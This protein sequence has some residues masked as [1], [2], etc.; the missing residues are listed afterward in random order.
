M[1]RCSNKK[2]VRTDT[3]TKKKIIPLMP[4][5][6]KQRMRNK[7]SLMDLDCRGGSWKK[8]LGRGLAPHHLRGNNG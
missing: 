1:I 6:P 3:K 4:V 5:I 8:Y 7:R 2:N